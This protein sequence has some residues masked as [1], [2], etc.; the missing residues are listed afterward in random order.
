M[1]TRTTLQTKHWPCTAS[2]NTRMYEQKKK[3][4]HVRAH[5]HTHTHTHTHNDLVC[6]TL[7]VE[8]KYWWWH[9]LSQHYNK[10]KHSCDQFDV[11]PHKHWKHI[12]CMKMA[13]S[14][15][16]FNWCKNNSARTFQ[17]NAMTTMTILKSMKKLLS[18]KVFC[19][20]LLLFHTWIGGGGKGHM[21]IYLLT[22]LYPSPC[23]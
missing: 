15:C 9:L 5:T 22:V 2:F 20:S 10:N 18:R 7:P 19:R 17:F 6:S 8:H 12:Q 11:S 13:Q 1:W 14:N 23:K 21:F 16:C 4:L 3:H